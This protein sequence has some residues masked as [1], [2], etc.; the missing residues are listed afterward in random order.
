MV[1]IDRDVLLWCSAGAGVLVVVA[2][3]A[4]LRARRALVRRVVTAAL[5]I[6]ENAPA[7][8]RRR[9]DPNLS[10]LERAIDRAVLRGGDATVAETRLAHALEAIPQGVV[11]CGD[12]GQV[13]YRNAAANRFATARHGEALVAAAVSELLD[14]ALEGRDSGRSLDLFGPPRRTLV[15]SACPLDDD[16]RTIGGLVVIDDV[17]ERRRLEA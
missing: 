4:W 17:S 14:A 3:F 10:R 13:V 1:E 7:T 8:E 9:L 2:L 11:I 15:L 6:E 5:R 12:N 16:R